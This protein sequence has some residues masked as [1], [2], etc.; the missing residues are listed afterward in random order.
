MLFCGRSSDETSRIAGEPHGKRQRNHALPVSRTE[1]MNVGVATGVGS[2]QRSGS[3]LMDKFLA[4]SALALSC[5]A[6]ASASAATIVGSEASS[7]SDPGIFFNYTTNVGGTFG[8]NDPT[9]ATGK[10]ADTFTFSTTFDRIATIILTSSRPADDFSRNVNFVSNGVR[11]NGTVVPIVTAGV[12]EL[13]ALFNF[14]LPA[15][16]STL[17]IRGSA[18]TNGTYIGQ[19]LFGGVPE[20]STWALMILGFG[21]IG[22]ALRRRSVKARVRFA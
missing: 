8:N 7:V 9:V 21:A 19:L 13:R 1:R 2:R 15:G 22:G 3:L 16:T 5:V 4:A 18:G 20:T 12:E 11:I 17:S 6:S 10:F 14:R